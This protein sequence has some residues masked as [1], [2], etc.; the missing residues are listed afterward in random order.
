M[1]TVLD[2][3]F[4]GKADLS[5]VSVP[6]LIVMALGVAVVILSGKLSGGVTNGRYYAFKLGGM[7]LVMIGAVIALKLFS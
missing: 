1:I 4:T 3:I 2:K 6:G 5:R 7:L